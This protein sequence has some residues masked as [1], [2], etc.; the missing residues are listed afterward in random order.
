MKKK[1]FLFIFVLLNGCA[2]AIQQ[3]AIPAPAQ[4]VETIP[5]TIYGVERE[6]LEETLSWA[7]LEAISVAKLRFGQGYTVKAV[8]TNNSNN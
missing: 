7:G 1:I 8:A 2:A 3:P 5:V 6:N 4:P